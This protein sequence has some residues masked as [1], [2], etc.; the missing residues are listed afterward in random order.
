MVTA[1]LIL[2]AAGVLGREWVMERLRVLAESGSVPKLD[3]RHAVAGLLLAA[4]AASWAMQPAAEGE[5]TPAPPAGPLVLAG[6][7]VGPTAAADAAAFACLCDELAACIEWDEVQKDPRLTT[8]VAIDE[9]RIAAREGRM[10]GDSIGDRHPLV[11]DSVRDYLDRTLGEPTTDASGRT[12]Y[13]TPGGPLTPE[14]RSRWKSALRTVA[15]AA[16][17]AIR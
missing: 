15:R 1:F 8:G 5:P 6:K 9:L 7:F 2:A 17:A 11:R 10:R 14:Q 3:S 13:R 12:V 4:A 16:E